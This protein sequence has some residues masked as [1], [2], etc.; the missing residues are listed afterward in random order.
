MSRGDL[1]WL[2]DVLEQRKLAD[3]KDSYTARLLAAGPGR[4]ARKLGE[5]AA[6]TIIAGIAASF[7][8]SKQALVEESA[9]LLYHLLVFLLAGGPTHFHHHLVGIET[10]GMGNHLLHFGWMLG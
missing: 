1:S 2:W 4:V 10:Q 5:E 3:P 9:D 7:G 6:E 8:E